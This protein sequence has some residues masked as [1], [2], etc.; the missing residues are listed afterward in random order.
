MNKKKLFVTALAVCLIAILSFSTLAWFSDEENVTNEF[1]VV[2]DDDED[3]DDIFSVDVFEEVDTDGD[4]VPERVEEGGAE[5]EDVVPGDVL[6]KAPYVE[7]T[8]RYDQW[9]RLTITFKDASAWKIISEGADLKTLLTFADDFDAN[10][11]ADRDGHIVEDLTEDTCTYVFY[12]KNVLTPDADPVA[13]FTNV[14]IPTNLTQDDLFATKGNALTIDVH[15]S[16]VQVEN[17]PASNA[18]DAFDFVE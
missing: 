16:A 17:V 13:T 11:T 3:A 8:G 15:A 6:D 18:E 2:T 7:N 5:F 14:K 10:W 1:F 12:L 9:I 4:G